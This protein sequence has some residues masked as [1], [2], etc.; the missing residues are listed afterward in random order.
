M[1]N[2]GFFNKV[3]VDAV[4]AAYKKMGYP[5]CE[6]G[7]YNLN[8]FGIR[9]EDD[10][11]SNNFNDVIGVL[12]KKAGN[13][14]LKV[15]DATTDP[16]LS[17]RLNPM[18]VNGVAVLVPGYYKGCWKVGLHQGKYQALKQYK[19]V[20]VY[21]DNNKDTKLNLDPKTIEEGMFGINI[22]RA[23]AV[24]GLTSKIVNGFSHGCQV[25]AA[26]N[27]FREFMTLV[28]TSAK[29][30]GDVFSYALFKQSEFFPK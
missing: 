18:N 13:W 22:H 8:I 12:Y 26:N 5:L 3:T 27:D 24:E 21:R 14:V 15:Y 25:V 19:P 11:D 4:I 2:A 17:G 9:N 16:G 30:Y 20:K 29:T 10:R 7:E 1:A 6:K 23:T 28:N